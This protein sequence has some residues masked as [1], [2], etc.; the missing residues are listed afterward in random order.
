MK[1]SRNIFS[2]ILCLSIVFTMFSGMCI[3]SAATNEYY[4]NT[5]VPSYTY[6]TG[7]KEYEN[8]TN[9]PGAI[10]YVYKYTDKTIM[11]DE[12][13]DYSALLVKKYD[14]V[15]QEDDVGSDYILTPYIRKDGIVNALVI[16]EINFKT[17]LVSVTYQIPPS[18]IVLEKKEIKLTVDKS[19]KLN[20]KIY[21]VGCTANGIKWVVSD[22]DIA[23]VTSD[24]VVKAKKI[25]TCKVYVKSTYDEMIYDVCSVNVVKENIT[26]VLFLNKEYTYDGTEKSIAV[27]GT[28]P[29][30]AKVEYTNEKATNAGIYNAT[31]K[32]TCEGYNDLTLNATLKINPKNLTVSGLT[33]QNKKYDGTD[34]ANLSGGSLN[35][36]ISGDDVNA[37]IP[38][39]G[40]FASANAGNNIAVNIDNITLAGTK[41]DNYTLKQPTGLKANIKK[42]EITVRANDK[43]MVKGGAIPKL[44]YAIIGELYGNDKITG[45]LKV[46]TDGKTVGDFD[47]TQ[48]TLAV[49]SNYK[50]TFEKGKLSV[51][52]KTPQNITVSEITEKTYGDAGFK[53]EVTKDAVSNLDTFT[54]AS[55]N[56][57]V[58]EITAD[59]TVTIKAA[60]ETDII[61]K[62]AGN[63]TYAP[64]EKTQ[65]L[66]VKKVSVTVTAEAKSKKIGAADPELTFTYTGDMVGDDK[67]TGKLERQAGE[68]VGK[69]DILIGTLAINNNY[70]ITYNKAVFEIFDKTPQNII[71]ADFGEKTYGDAAF[72]VSVTSDTAANL[73]NY[74]FESD[75]TDVAEIT[76]DGNITI[77]AAGEANITV[78]EP[79]NDEYAPF[80]KTVKLVVKKKAV[81]VTSVDIENKTAVLDGVLAEDAEN[82]TLDFDKITIEQGEA[83]DETTSNI[84]LKNFVLKGD[85]AANYEI[86]TETLPGTIANDNIVDITITAENGVVTGAAKY[87]K[88]SSV[89]VTATANSGYRFTGWY[90]DDAAVSTE[91]TYT[92][93]AESD[94]ALTAKFERVRSSG[95]GG[96]GGSSSTCTINFDTNGGSKVASQSVTKN[97]VIKEPAAPTKEGFDFA[98]WYTDKELKTK[99]D[100]SAKVTKSLTLYAAWTQKDNS[101]NQIVL[102][103]GEKSATVFGQ[104]KSNDVAPKIVN[105][106]TM[107]PAR[108]VAESLG[109]VVTWDGEKQEVTIKG[110]NA[111]NE[112]ITILIYIDSDIAYVNGE[113]VK[114]DS[115]AF[116]ENDRTY[117]PIRFISVQLGASV[118]W[119]ETDKTVTITK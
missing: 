36:K 58:A 115:P 6:I 112:D 15:W 24:G 82:A 66:V 45:E 62:Q 52:D 32:I 17:M 111:K 83:V 84:T 88:G 99:Y 76:A 77:K 72:A 78:K 94:T 39:T 56:P 49:S 25:G 13:S 29:T 41:K 86:T 108:F 70:D 19:E 89:T 97:S 63:D 53:V 7:H 34:T 69:Y 107:L 75:N 44:D 116:V 57:S 79:G 1:N 65:K 40:R 20:A 31:A 21:P 101:L 47:I 61:V 54:Y 55:S 95:G 16:L 43:Q 50:L 80:E 33:A 81:T 9:L 2:L 5:A 14:F 60:G 102:T 42:A 67:F 85:K 59:G 10:T 28:L 98:G 38:A 4:P 11:S 74:T 92:F 48:G 3:V 87:I 71:V 46:N 105:N 27:T 12:W 35:G 91:S 64:F 109:A 8:N 37:D 51:V 118:E 117:T 22:T 113:Q 96:I 103:I 100:F 30:G 110:K 18:S 26:G 119:N 68:D 114:L 93:T 73:T 23:S 90:F 106:R 104:T